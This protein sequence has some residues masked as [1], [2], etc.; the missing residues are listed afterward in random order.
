MKTYFVALKAFGDFLIAYQAIKQVV[1]KT[2]GMHM[3]IIAGRHLK[4]LADALKIPSDLCMYVGDESSKNVPAAFDLRS[5]GV[6]SS[7]ESLI[8]LRR[9]FSSIATNCE[10]IFDR[11]GWRERFIA[12][13][14]KS[15]ALPANSKNIYIAYDKLLQNKGLDAT[16][17]P[18]RVI[19]PPLSAF[20]VPN[21]RVCRKTIPAVA[22]STIHSYLLESGVESTILQLEGESFEI[23]AHLPTR[24]LPRNFA[25]L[26][27]A[28]REVDLVISAD[29]FPAHL[30]EY[31]GVPTFVVTAQHNAYWLPRNAFLTNATATFDDLSALPIWLA[32][33][34]GCTEKCK[35]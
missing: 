24:T 22:L 5:R 21:S 14:V 15:I 2:Q 26:I 31:L 4:P 28:L 11:L 13:K 10:L 34:F 18:Q 9:D 17:Y 35:S 27:S 25:T 8:G 19:S 12:G 29:S 7:V 1:S 3:A 30:G 23:P 20:I 6:F 33:L 32:G 16:L